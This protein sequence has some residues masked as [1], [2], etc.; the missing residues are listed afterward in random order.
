MSFILMI[1]ASL[2][3]SYL[4]L[5]IVFLFILHEKLFNCLCNRHF[6]P[7]V[8]LADCPAGCDYPVWVSAQHAVSPLSD[9]IGSREIYDAR[10]K[11]NSSVSE[12]IQE[13]RWVWRDEWN[14][15]YEVLRQIQVPVLNDDWKD[16]AV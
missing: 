6:G 12:I 11:D 15:D 1:L 5:Q 9:V 10:F 2:Q 3:S 16:K 8:C 4:F 13:G 14:N 7:A